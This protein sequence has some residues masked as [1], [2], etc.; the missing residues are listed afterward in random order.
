MRDGVSLRISITV[1]D[2]DR[3]RLSGRVFERGGLVGGGV[4]QSRGNRW[5]RLKPTQAI[6]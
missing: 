4:E 3:P 6:F 2:S 5:D 1:P